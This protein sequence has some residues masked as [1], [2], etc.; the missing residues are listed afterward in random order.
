MLARAFGA[1]SRLESL[2]AHV[3]DKKSASATFAYALGHRLPRF[4]DKLYLPSQREGLGGL[5]P[6]HARE[7]TVANADLRK[8]GRRF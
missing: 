6:V 1:A 8:I 7:P 3:A 4:S 5:D 2:G